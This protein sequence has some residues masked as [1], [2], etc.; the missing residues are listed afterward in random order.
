MAEKVGTLL[1]LV[2]NGTIVLP[3]F[4]R[5]YVWNR[6]QVRAFMRSLYHRYP[7]GSLLVWRTRSET[8]RLRGSDDPPPGY[9]DL[10]LDGQQ[11]LTTLYGIVR[12]RPPRFFEGNAQAFTGLQFH[13]DD[14]VFEFY[15]PIKMRND[16]RWI[17]VTTVMREGLDT[18]IQQISSSE[19]LAPRLGVY[20]GRLARLQQIKEIEFHI[21]RISG[22]DKT[23]D[24]V[25][26]VFNRVNSGGTKLSK[27]DLALASLCAEWPDTRDRMRAALEKWSK[28]GFRFRLEWLL[29]VANA[30]VTGEAKFE[31]LARVTATDFVAGLET[32]EKA[33]DTLLNNVSAHLGLDHDRVLAGRYAFIV[34]AR[35]LVNRGGRFGDATELGRLLYWYVHSFLLGRYTGATETTLNQD[36]DAVDDGGVDRLLD[37]LRSSRGELSVRPEY[38][39]GYGIGARFYPLLYMLTRAYGAR[40]WWNGA[41]QLSAHLLGKFAKLQV[42]HIFPKAVLYANGYTYPQVNALA[43][44]C[45]LTTETNLWVGAREPEEYFETVEAHYPGALA[46]QWIPM[47]R[48]L[49]KTSRYLDFLAARRELLAE[50]ANNFLEGLVR[51]AEAAPAA[52]PVAMLGP[53]EVELEVDDERL[54]VERLAA[55]AVGE[56]LTEPE[57]DVELTDPETGAPLGVAELAWLGGLQEGL[58]EPV[59]L[60]LEL[61]DEVEERLAAYGYRTFSDPARLRDF[62]ERYLAAEAEGAA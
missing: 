13:L 41:P 18:F 49:W 50:A 48:S 4:Q 24:V 27:A 23:L 52:A 2:D 38:L 51:T 7:V 29:R 32:T 14:E 34:M 62:I 35:H 60:D 17:D 39:T 28:A 61:S 8:A 53:A 45:F 47:D 9:L 30:V 1:D 6:D 44:F 57:R 33:I 36:L 20:V 15:A 16:P 46:S 3:E 5:G 11:R 21:E 25:V 56:G 54:E 58:G 55:W 19:L 10:L 40:D 12:G 43:N 59:I 37:L 26:E 31:A 42:H 22:E